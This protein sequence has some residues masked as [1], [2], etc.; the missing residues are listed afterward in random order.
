MEFDIS[1]RDLARTLIFSL[2]RTRAPLTKGRLL[3]VPYYRKRRR[4]LSGRQPEMASLLVG[5]VSVG[6]YGDD[7]LEWLWPNFCASRGRASRWTEFR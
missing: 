3:Y 1:I 2:K 6:A 7:G 4:P 5:P